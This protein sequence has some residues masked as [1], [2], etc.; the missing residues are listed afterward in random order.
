[1]QVAFDVRVW[2]PGRRWE[3]VK[4]AITGGLRGPHHVPQAL[5]FR[6]AREARDAHVGMEC[7]PPVAMQDS[8]RPKGSRDRG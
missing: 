2:F 7:D 5:A 8:M 3:I 4:N 6:A 1:M